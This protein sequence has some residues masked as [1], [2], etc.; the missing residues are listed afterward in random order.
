MLHFTYRT[1]CLATGKYYLGRHSTR[2]S[3]DKDT[4]LG[5]G[6]WIRRALKVHGRQNFKRDI[7]AFYS[8]RADLILAEEQLVTLGILTDPLCMN[9]V[10]GGFGNDLSIEVAKRLEVNP[11]CLRE[12][13]MRGGRE[14][15]KVRNQRALTD[16]DYALRALQNLELG[17]LALQN[18]LDSDPDYRLRM[19]QA[20]KER[21]RKNLRPAFTREDGLRAGKERHRRMQEDLE[22]RASMVGVFK[23]NGAVRNRRMQEDPE[24]KSQ[25]EAQLSK[26]RSR[27]QELLDSD[28]SFRE[29]LA[30]AKGSRW[31]SS[32][33]LRISRLVKDPTEFLI[34]GWVLG[35]HY[36]QQSKVI[37]TRESLM[38]S[39]D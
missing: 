35:R 31:I 28:P 27:R 3:L 25:V 15:W 4:Y 29:K 1:T 36:K 7:L 18:Q 24:F 13:G 21:G 16:P 39:E 30:S 5:S 6:V 37:L 2:K 22:F 12:Q 8:S 33:E 23:N 17:R 19:E 11:D 20:W 9:M 38:G 32:P 14:S 26:A 10:V 34:C